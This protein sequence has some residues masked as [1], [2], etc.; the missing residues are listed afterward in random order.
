[1][2][3]QFLPAT[4]IGVVFALAKEEV[5]SSGKSAGGEA[6]VEGVG[7]LVG[8]D[9]DLAEVALEGLFHGGADGVGQGLAAG[10]GAGYG[11]FQS[12]IQFAT[13]QHGVGAL[14]LQQPP[15]HLVAHTIRQ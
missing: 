12:T 14:S 10:F 7:L 13:G 11:R 2:G 3:Q 5:L 6:L 4:G 9:F 15:H 1:M 8:V